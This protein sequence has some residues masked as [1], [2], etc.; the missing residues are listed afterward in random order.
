MK[1]E[2]VHSPLIQFL[3]STFLGGVL[4][5]LPIGLAAMLVMK[6]VDVLRG[7][8]DP[9]TSHLPDRLR[10]PTLIASALLFLACFFAG[11]LAR[12]RAG[13][14]C[15]SFIERAILGHIPGY[16]MVR[17]FVH[18]LGNIEES[19]SL[20]PALV[21]IEDA[22]VPAFVV[23][24]HADNRCTVFVPSAPTP[25]VGAIYIMAMARVHLLDISMLKTMK[26]VSRWGAGS[27]ELLKAM[28]DGR[29]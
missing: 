4:V 27:E 18:S 12:T 2:P 1:T 26:C 5:I 22:L 15:G 10:F 14:A 17:A 19:D 25:A 20:K 21:E 13:R 8:L 16:A 11:L 9:I 24:V 6:I 7:V 28:R 3:Q 29:R 23:E